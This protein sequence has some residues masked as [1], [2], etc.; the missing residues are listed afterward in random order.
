MS[1][2]YTPLQIQAEA[3]RRKRERIVRRDRKADERETPDHRQAESDTR[4]RLERARAFKGNP[5]QQRTR[6][7]SREQ[8]DEF[9]VESQRR[10]AT[11]AAKAAFAEEI[12]AVE[13]GGRRG[14]E[15]RITGGFITVAVDRGRCRDLL[16]SWPSHR[17]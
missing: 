8:Q 17:R 9:A 4:T 10:A 16:E 5:G 3:Q 1:A 12:T 6:G 2:G 7:V 11:D 13:T 15:G 14:L